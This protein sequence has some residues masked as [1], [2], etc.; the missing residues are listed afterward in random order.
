MQICL[1]VLIFVVKCPNNI[2]YFSHCETSRRSVDSSSVNTEVWQDRISRIV[3][4][5]TFVLLN[6]TYWLA[7]S[8]IFM[9]IRSSA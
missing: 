8:D 5:S 1:L 4:P 6:I 3:F 9:S 7:F 2:L